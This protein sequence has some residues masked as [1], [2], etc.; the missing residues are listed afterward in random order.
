MNRFIKIF[1]LTFG[2]I[3]TGHAE[4][5]VQED[6]QRFLFEIKLIAQ[7]KT[8]QLTKSD[9]TYFNKL[10]KRFNYKESVIIYS[11]TDLKLK[12]D[13]KT[14]NGIV[15]QN[16]QD[17]SQLLIDLRQINKDNYLL[18]ANIRFKRIGRPGTGGISYHPTESRKHILCLNGKGNSNGIPIDDGIKGGFPSPTFTSSIISWYYN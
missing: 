18:V 7:F 12:R 5:S 16:I 4:P 17:K 6:K 15:Y 14:Y 11:L 1:A 3:I 2:L 8:V 9:S 10:I 13:D